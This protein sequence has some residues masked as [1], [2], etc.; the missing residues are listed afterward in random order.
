M[1]VMSADL[2]ISKRPRQSVAVRFQSLLAE[3]KADRAPSSSVAQLAMHPAYQQIIGL[4][5]DVMPMIFR[6]MSTTPGHWFWALR[7]LSGENP[8]EESHRGDVP[9]MTEDWL[10]WARQEGYSW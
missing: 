3:W 2:P 10:N 8:V 7:A 5:P 9:K 6:E 1:S 4:G